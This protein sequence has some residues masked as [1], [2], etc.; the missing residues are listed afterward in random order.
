MTDFGVANF[1]VVELAAGILVVDHEW[2]A[3]VLNLR[4]LAEQDYIDL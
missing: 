3:D 2:R 4:M 1:F